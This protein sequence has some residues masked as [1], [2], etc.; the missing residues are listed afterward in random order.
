MKLMF[1]EARYNKPIFIE[2]TA[3]KLPEKIGLV[4]TIQFIEHLKNIKKELEKHKK[5]VFVGKGSH[6]AYPGQVLGCDVLA[7]SSVKERVDAFL[8]IGTGDFHPIAISLDTKKDVFVFNP[9]T[10]NLKKIDFKEAEKIN[11]KKKGALIR[12]FS[13]NEI[14]V[15]LTTKPGQKNLEKAFELKKSFKE[16]NFYFILFDTIDFTQL[17]N[18]PFIECFINTACPRIAMDDS[19]KL[20]RSIINIGDLR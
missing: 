11:K 19:I 16:K 10:K 20:E 4:A 1:V 14:G 7:A 6:T 5:T 9:I 18:F 12:F 17:E 2:K 8:Y 15:I 3:S 13:S